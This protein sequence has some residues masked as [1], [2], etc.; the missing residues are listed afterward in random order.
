MLGGDSPDPFD[1]FCSSAFNDW[2]TCEQRGKEFINAG[3]DESIA[4]IKAYR[5]ASCEKNLYAPFEKL[6]NHALQYARQ[7]FPDDSELSQQHNLTVSTAEV[8]T[9]PDLPP[10]LLAVPTHS[11]PI[12]GCADKRK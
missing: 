12:H 11:R 7:T 9:T 6:A 10:N 5:G 1:H 8:N 4:A 2:D 3:D